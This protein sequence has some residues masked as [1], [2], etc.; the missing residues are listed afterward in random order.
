M[1][2]SRSSTEDASSSYPQACA[3]DI[4]IIITC[5]YFGKS[6]N[7]LI[8]SL[9]KCVKRPC[10]W[11]L[12]S[13]RPFSICSVEKWK[14][15][16]TQTGADALSLAHFSRHTL[17]VTYIKLFLQRR[18]MLKE[19]ANMPGRP[20][21]V[22]KPPF[23]HRISSEHIACFR[24]TTNKGDP[25]LLFPCCHRRPRCVGLNGKILLLFII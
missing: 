1:W 18:T 12:M 17:R 25:V 10:V 5:I 23:C 8:I 21:T 24:E 19:D 7:A 14:W 2:W 6:N 16:N 22:G 9:G 13:L 11:F 15:Y 3:R 20:L 4:S